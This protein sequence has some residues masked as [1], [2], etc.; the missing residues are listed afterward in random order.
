MDLDDIVR[1]VVLNEDIHALLTDILEGRALREHPFKKLVEFQRDAYAREGLCIK[2]E[3]FQVGEPWDGDIAN[4]RVAFI[5]SNPAFDAIEDFPRYHA[6]TR[7]LSTPD[8]S[9]LS[10]SDAKDFFKYR[11]QRACVS[12]NGA[13]LRKR[14]DG[15][16]AVNYWGCVRNS[17]EALWPDAAC[18]GDSR[19]VYVKRLM[20]KAVTMEIVP[21]KSSGEKGVSEAL[22]ICMKIF[23]RHI[24]PHVAAPIIVLVGKKVRSA[25]L[26][27]ATETE[28]EWRNAERI[29]DN[30]EAY[31]Y[32]GP[33][34]SGKKL[35]VSVGFNAGQFSK[36]AN[37]VSLVS[38]VSLVN[39]CTDSTMR[40]LQAVFCNDVK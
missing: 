3:G 25:F 23:T 29:F 26:Y 17:M 14:R 28:E 4:A 32:N 27:L 39:D 35:V 22:L 20:S 37:L 7:T 21:F 31:H 38:L 8:G 19:E 13:L 9:T 1:N 36:L 6:E 2:K 40:E 34:C 10:L 11:F 18:P 33:L 15:C 5:S 12:P 16:R 30:Q 24:L